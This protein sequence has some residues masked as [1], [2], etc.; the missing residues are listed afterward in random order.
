MPRART[1]G[2][3]ME[4]RINLRVPDEVRVVFDR[5]QAVGEVP[6]ELVREILISALPALRGLADA[7]E[8]KMKG[9]LINADELL[10]RMIR[11]SLESTEEKART[12]ARG[13]KAA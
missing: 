13:R 2:E 3:R 10:G 9:L 6:S 1:E 12:I 11:E 4:G 8:A 7:K 5:L